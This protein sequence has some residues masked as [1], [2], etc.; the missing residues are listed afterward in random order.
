MREKPDKPQGISFDPE[1]DRTMQ[2]FKDDADINK[3]MGKWRT[4]GFAPTVNLQ[5]PLYGDFSEVKTYMEAL[6]AVEE[7]DALFMQVPARIRRLCEDDPSKLEAFI[8]DPANEQLLVD[9]K[10]LINQDPEPVSAEPRT[11]PEVE[12]GPDD[13]PNEGSGTSPTN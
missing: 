12:T 11:S 9:H 7:A 13:H 2:Q 4:Q 10:V 1:E 3:V 8:A 6:N 5:T